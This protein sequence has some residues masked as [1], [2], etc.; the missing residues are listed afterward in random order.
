VDGSGGV[1]VA[2]PVELSDTNT[3]IY[4]RY[5]P[6]GGD[7]GPLMRVTDN[8]AA[9]LDPSLAV[10]RGDVAHLAWRSNSAGVYDIFYSRFEEGGWG[11][12]ENV[13]ETGF[14]SIAP[15]VAADAAGNVYVAWAD[16]MGGLDHFQILCRRWDGSSWWPWTHVSATSS[17]RALSPALAADGDGNL[18]AVWADYRDD[19][20]HPEVYFSH[21]TN[22]GTTWLGDENVTQNAT[23]SYY[24][25]VAARPGGYAH[26]VWT[27]MAPGQPDIYYSRAGVQ[28]E[29]RFYLP[30]VAK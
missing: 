10:G 25:D 23:S 8:A 11:P 16:E 6:A 12:A 9:D 5:R 26:I 21:S 13:S 14:Y 1:W 19:L 29:V 27:D 18:Y 2:W 20:A 15:D 28:V 24:P 22:F 30:V 17:P 3:E 4:A 7:W